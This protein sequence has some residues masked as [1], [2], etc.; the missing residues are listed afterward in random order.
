MKTLIK[1]ALIVESLIL[2]S[3]PIRTYA[4]DELLLP[5]RQS[6]G[7]AVRYF[8]DHELNV[9][10]TTAE[11]A[12]VMVH[13][14]RGGNSD[15]TGRV[16]RILEGRIQAE[17]IY[18]IAPCFPIG[19]ML[20]ED[21]QKRIV[22]WNENQWQAGY[23]SPVAANLSP[24][25]V[26]DAI[27]A[28]LNDAHL[29]PNLK[30]VLF[31]GYSAGAQVISRYMAVSSIKARKGLSF[32]FAAG[33]PSSWLFLDTRVGWHYGL[34]H[35]CRYAREV[36]NKTLLNNIKSRHMVCFCGTADTGTE[37]LSTKPLAMKQGPNRYARFLNFKRHIS[38]FK[39]LKDSFEFQEIADVGHSGE[40]WE[41]MDFVKMLSVSGL[42]GDAMPES[43]KQDRERFHEGQ[44]QNRPIW[45]DAQW[46]K[47]DPQECGFNSGKLAEI[48]AFIKSRNM[49]TTG[50]M[51]VVGGKEMYSYGDVEQVS[52]IA[53]CRKS[54]LSMLYG[55]YVRNGI[56]DLEATVGELGID[57]VGGLLPKEKLATVR[58]LITARSG[59]YHPAA[60]TGGIPE[61]T[62][63]ERG[64]TEPGTKFVYNNWDFNVAGTVF[65]MMTQLSIYEAFDK[66]IAEPL[67][68]QDWKLSSHKRTGNA[69][70]SW[71]LAYHF[72]LSTRDMAKLGELM[73]RKG[74]W[75]GEQVIP[76]DW[77]EE[78]T[79]P[80]T[81][82]PSGGGYGYMWWIETDNLHSDAYRGAFAAHGMY[83][84]RIS[85]F[86]A[87]DMV[88]AHKSANN[89]KHPTNGG[90]YRE[91]IRLILAA[92]EGPLIVH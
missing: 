14:V 41:R 4:S 24:Y 35:R 67:M 1:S 18:Y 13:G 45:Y 54:V 90:D 79:Q 37:N 65:E 84:Q 26:L 39:D 83:G 5:V 28:K 66:D 34:N 2:A 68:L 64:V 27:F 91:L 9:V 60:N 73:L 46:E 16:R 32:S 40:C 53:S 77:V 47:V 43:N 75:N 48:P 6:G 59:C 49:G 55:K 31:C 33:A 19:P 36:S 78:S 57:D 74:V 8:A 10:D 88:V 38:T 20:G 51:I 72:N 21:C 25:D 69:S 23:D 22:Y 85:V 82:F 81:S 71:H 70:K 62:Q 3:L 86:P 44:L 30:H 76:A 63:L 56:I 12:I 92:Y 15:C 58:N 52:Y 80:V 87:L 89:A 7:R 61:G 29:Y 42:D 11:Y 17:S 50:L